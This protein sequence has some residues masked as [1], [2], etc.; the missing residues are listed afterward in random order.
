[1]VKLLKNLDTKGDIL[2]SHCIFQ[3]ESLYKSVLSLRHVLNPN[4]C[5]EFRIRALEFHRRQ[6]KSLHE[7]VINE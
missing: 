3:P 4:V 6:F 5:D 1:M 7:D 2:F